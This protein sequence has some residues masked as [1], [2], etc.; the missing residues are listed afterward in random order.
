MGSDEPRNFIR[1]II[2]D[3]LASDRHQTVVTRFPPEPNGYLHIGH[4]KSICLNFGLAESFGGRCHLRFDDTNPLKEDTEYV[5][6]IMADVHWLGFD[7]GEHLYYASDYF[8]RMYLF[9]VELIGKGL[10]Y[11]DSQTVEEIRERRG[12]LGVPG[13]ASPFR[14]R[15]ADESLDIFAK[16]RGGGFEDGA[17]VLRA[18]IDMG[19][20][21]MLMR[22]PLLYRIR[23]TRHHRTGDVWCIY[24]MYDFAHCLSD[25]IEGITHS[26]CTLEFEN[27]RELYDWVLDNVDAPSRPRQYEFARLSLAN[28]LMSKRKLLRLVEEERVAGWDDP[29][30]PTIAGMRRRGYRA[31]A[32]RSFAEMIGVAK[33]N[34]LVD[35]EKVQYCVRDDLNHEAPRLMGVLDPVE[36]VVTNYPDGGNEQLTCSYWPHDVPKEGTR[37]VPF[38]GSLYI[39]RSDFAEKPPKGW[40]R[41]TPG[42]EVRLR[43][44][45]V[46]M[47]TGVERDTETGDVTRVLCT[48][49][50]ATRGGATPDGRKVP[51]TIHWVDGHE[52]IAVEARL[53]DRLFVDERPGAE[54]DFL[55]ALNPDSARATKGAVVEPAIAGLGPGEHVQLERN[56]YFFTDPQDSKPG[57]VVLNRVVGLKDSWAN[58]Q[59]RAATPGPTPEVDEEAQ[60]DAA[61]PSEKARPR[62]R[63]ARQHREAA[64]AANPELADRLATYQSELGLSE[65][66]ARLLTGDQAIADFFDAALAAHEAPASVAKWVINEVLRARKDSPLSELAFDGAAIGRLAALVDAHTIS[67]AGGKRVFAEL[68]DH[69]GDPE[70]IVDAL[71]LRQVS[72]TGAIAVIVAEVVAAHPEQAARYR[73]GKTALL[74]FFVGQVMKASRGQAKPQL[75]RELVQEALDQPS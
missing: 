12:S 55:E 20:S 66:D 28:T 44:A 16:M 30:M 60:D 33:A 26:I 21:N 4:A 36:L 41:M 65:H 5:E 62:K 39:E 69:G 50:P 67:S 13:E 7:W 48:Y 9:A 45:Y 75:A 52:G 42:R 38:S 15:P 18:K 3:D 6:S 31:E 8:E 70:A 23:H 43:Y 56:G 63:S 47:C 37:E 72:D 34:S 74:G 11:V 61:A 49:D 19:A 40:R 73:D 1:T 29:R 10:A 2:E 14:D 59:K 27:N 68:V 53:Y 54:R 22:D 58:L 51:G 46:V 35:F 57:A 64:R 24:P 25:A 32:I 71:G 17:H